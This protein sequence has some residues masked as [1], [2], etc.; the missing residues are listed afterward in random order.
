MEN[1]FSEYRN[2]TGLDSESDSEI[3]DNSYVDN[4]IYSAKKKLTNHT[5]FVAESE[6]SASGGKFIKFILN[7]TNYLPIK[8]IQN[9]KQLLTPRKWCD[10]AAAIINTQIGT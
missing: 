8:T 2:K 4:V 7:F 5:V 10:S 6:E 1:S 3:I 9:I